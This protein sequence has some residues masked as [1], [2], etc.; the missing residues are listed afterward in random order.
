MEP[1]TPTPLADKLTEVMLE[2]RKVQAGAFGVAWLFTFAYTAA[3]KVW[4]RRA[5]PWQ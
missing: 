3:P 1:I 2:N 4:S 5:S